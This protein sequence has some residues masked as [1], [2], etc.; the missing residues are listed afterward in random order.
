ML[1]VFL[2]SSLFKRLVP[3]LLSTYPEMKGTLP[4]RDLLISCVSW[5]CITDVF[6]STVGSTKLTWHEVTGDDMTR[7]T[8][9]SKTETTLLVNLQQ[10]YTFNKFQKVEKT[11]WAVSHDI[12]L[13]KAH[14]FCDST[15]TLCPVLHI[16]VC[17]G[18]LIW[19][20]GK[21]Q[22]GELPG[23]GQNRMASYR[24]FYSACLVSWQAARVILN[25]FFTH[26]LDCPILPLLKRHSLPISF[27]SSFSL[28]FGGKLHV[29]VLASR[30]VWDV[31]L[32]SGLLATNDWETVSLVKSN[33]HGCH[34]HPLASLVTKWVSEEAEWPQS[35]WCG[36]AMGS[37]WER[38][39]W[40]GGHE[41]TCNHLLER[42]LAEDSES[43][44]T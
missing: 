42:W 16:A 10:T 23:V 38:G 43:D 30:L 41:W 25:W 27:L 17:L 22:F 4:E 2:C 44:Y 29:L 11:V 7:G 6:C 18:S 37:H 8:G 19:K 36:S 14:P 15:G 31:L 40:R 3:E 1:W 21:W 13:M 24:V 35:H 39:R 33:C 20:Q 26:V 34:S 9:Y 28:M 5:H 12:F 32:S